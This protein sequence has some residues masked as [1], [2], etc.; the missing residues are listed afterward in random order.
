MALNE[1][2]SGGNWKTIIAHSAFVFRMHSSLSFFVIL[3][4]CGADVLGFKRKTW[5]AIS[6]ARKIPVTALHC[7][8]IPRWSHGI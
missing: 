2:S 6:L 7:M 8:V 4:M 1:I 3:L 5:T